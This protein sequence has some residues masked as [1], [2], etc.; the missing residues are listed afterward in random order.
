MKIRELIRAA[1]FYFA[2][3][4]SCRVR[5]LRNWLWLRK[6]DAQNWLLLNHNWNWHEPRD[7]NRCLVCKQWFY[8]K[9]LNLFRKWRFYRGDCPYCV[10][11][12]SI[13]E[14]IFEGN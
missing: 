11:H 2:Y 10:C 6:V 4:V 3:K 8:I 14:H 12:D 9:Q 5:L 1:R 13:T 7:G